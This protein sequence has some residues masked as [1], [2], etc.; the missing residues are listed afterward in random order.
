MSWKP[1]LRI[2]QQLLE[3]PPSRAVYGPL[4]TSA[5][6]AAVAVEAHFVEGAPLPDD[7]IDLAAEIVL[8]IGEAD[9]GS[10]P[11][12]FEGTFNEHAPDRSAARALPCCSCLLLRHFA[13][14]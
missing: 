9:F 14:A 7:T 11:F 3:N 6:V 4:E 1:I 13:F 8:E 2:V 10:R 5:M 12:E